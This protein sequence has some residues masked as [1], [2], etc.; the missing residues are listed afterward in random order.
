MKDVNKWNAQ[1]VLDNVFNNTAGTSNEDILNEAGYS[2]LDILLGEYTNKRNALAISNKDISAK[3]YPL[4]ILTMKATSCK[5][6]HITQFLT[7]KCKRR[8]QK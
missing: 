3:I 5:A 8:R 2:L 4:A 1:S 7:E 6:V